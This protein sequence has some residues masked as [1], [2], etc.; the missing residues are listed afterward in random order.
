M[1]ATDERIVRAARD[2]F[3]YEQLRPGQHEAI[4]ALVEGSDVLAVM[5]T[6]SGKS[7]I[8]QVAGL[9]LE[10]PTL[11]VSPLI[12]L[13]QDQVQSITTESTSTA[14]RANSAISERVRREALTAVGAG[15]VE[16]LFVAPEQFSNEGT[17]AAIRARPPSLFVVDEAH[18]ISAWGHDFRTD[19]LHLAPVIEELGH[20]RVLALT[21]TATPPVR[22]EIVERLGMR[23]PRLVVHGFDRPNIHLAAERF[24]DQASKEAALVERVGATEGAGIVYAATRAGTEA[25]ANR[26]EA[27]GEKAS[28]YHGGMGSREREVT[29]ERFMSGELR[30]VVA[31]T[32]FGMGVDKPDVRFV[33][34]HDVSESLD[35]YYH[36]IGRAGRDGEPAQAVLFFRPEDMALRRFFAA[37]AE[38]EEEELAELVR[39]VRRRRRAVT[40]DKLRDVTGLSSGRLS[41]AIGWLDRTGALEVDAG[42]EWVR[43]PAGVDAAD[44]AEEAS[45]AAQAHRRLDR[46][47]VEMVRGYAETRG[48]RRR[49]LLGYFGEGY[50]PPCRACD[51]C[52]A[53]LPAEDGEA[54]AHGFTAGDRVSHTVLG[55]GTVMGVEDDKVVVLFDDNG[56]KTLLADLVV[57]QGLLRRTT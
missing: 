57:E 40:F 24:S 34:H 20:P 25:L 1:P 8:Y 26:L 32:A 17:M 4:A 50:D 11:V 53:G 5:P 48:C 13:Q 38:F 7:A 22:D 6:G 27:A 39:A 41:M 45:D 12:S 3:G 16:F 10:G 54:G 14:V 43:A 21:A 2:G 19:Y 52:D 37:S 42:G 33:F 47:R 29:Q 35:A 23:R 46:S 30:V 49:F 28:A 9:L 31:T 44:A 36:E 15:E 18:C 55:E 51:N 56:Y